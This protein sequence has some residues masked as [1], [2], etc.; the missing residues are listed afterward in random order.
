MFALVPLADCRH[1]LPKTFATASTNGNLADPTMARLTFATPFGNLTVR[2]SDDHLV[3]LW[4]GGEPGGDETPLT[5]AAR[6]QFTAYL[7]GEHRTFSLPIAPAGTEFQRGAWDEI[8]RV[9]YGEIATYGG[10]A[11]ALGSGPRAL[12]GACARNP[13]PLIIPCHRVVAAGGHLGGYSGGAG[14]DTKRALL[15]LEGSLNR[16]R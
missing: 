4:W 1:G 9:A 13:L 8:A 12:A 14:L 10:L 3:G 6:E 2:E 16:I 15:R 5:T 11:A 7:A